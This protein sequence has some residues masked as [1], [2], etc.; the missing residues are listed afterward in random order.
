LQ[1]FE[2]PTWLC[3]DRPLD[4]GNA[5]ITEVIKVEKI[6]I[7]SPWV[8]TYLL[9]VTA[10]WIVFFIDYYQR[11]LPTTRDDSGTPRQQPVPSEPL[12]FSASECKKNRQPVSRPGQPTD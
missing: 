10:L 7:Y 11:K 5:R 4:G 3:P 8:Q 1:A 9:I 2:P 6:L 12:R